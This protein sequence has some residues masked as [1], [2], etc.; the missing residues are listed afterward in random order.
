M[1]KT[2]KKITMYI[3]NMN[4]QVVKLKMWIVNTLNKILVNITLAKL[5]GAIITA[6]LITSIKY[7]LTGDIHIDWGDYYTN[8]S[9][10]LLGW[11]LKIV[12]TD[13][14]SDLLNIKGLNLNLKKI[15]YGIETAKMGDESML[16]KSKPKLYCSMDSDE[17]MESDEGSISK[18][19]KSLDKGKGVDLEAHPNYYGGKK[20][21]EVSG[22]DNKPLDKGKGIDK[23]E[24]PFYDAF[25]SKIQPDTQKPSSNAESDTKKPFSIWSKLNPGLDPIEAFFPKK[26]NPGPGF[27][28]PGGIVPIRDDICQHI[29]WNTHILNQ[30]RKMD[31]ETAIQ[32]RDNYSKYVEA[33]NAKLNHAHTTLAKIPDTPTTEYEFR[34]K[35]KII[36][37]LESLNKA[38]IRSEAKAALLNSRIE[39]IQIEMNKNTNESSK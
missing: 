26:T 1:R 5:S 29:D 19:G 22:Y 30:F 16:S 21:S 27:N 12:F 20:E 9:L 15:L 2:M 36:S 8:F 25:K 7:Y 13:L 32:Q 11:F 24:H 35:Q 3:M 31:L 39:F 34:L 10:G 18:S 6:L 17:N 38:K 28:V 4:I 14:F 33:I 37:D 23:S